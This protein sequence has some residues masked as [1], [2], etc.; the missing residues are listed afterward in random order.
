MDEKRRR[1]GRRGGEKGGGRRRGLSLISRHM[2]VCYLVIAILLN[3]IKI[4]F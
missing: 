2:T 1:G 3:F 4:T